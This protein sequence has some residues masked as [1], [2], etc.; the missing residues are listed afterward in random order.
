MHEGRRVT[1]VFDVT[2]AGV[3][4]NNGSVAH[5][6]V[7]VRQRQCGRSKWSKSGAAQSSARSGGRRSAAPESSERGRS[8]RG[9]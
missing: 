9:H 6:V 3:C 2:A 1:R 8:R 4:K 5:S 7:T